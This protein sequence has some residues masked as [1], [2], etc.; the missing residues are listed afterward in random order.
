M[1]GEKAGGGGR[2]TLRL[3]TMLP[4]SFVGPHRIQRDESKCFFSREVSM[5]KTSLFLGAEPTGNEPAGADAALAIA[6]FRE[7]VRS[8][9]CSCMHL[10]RLLKVCRP[11]FAVE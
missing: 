7:R 6:L 8:S 3:Q 10:T 2:E 9:V 11:S 4:I 1:E 5:W